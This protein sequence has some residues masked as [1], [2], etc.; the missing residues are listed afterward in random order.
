[1]QQSAPPI[2]ENQTVLEALNRCV[3]ACENCITACLH[4]EHVQ[5]MVGCILLDRDCAD[6][7]ALT[8]RFV[9]RGSAHAKHVMRECIELCQLCHTECAKHNDTHCQQC[10]AACKACIEVCKA[11]LG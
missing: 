10:A 4:E 1:M 9:A 11:Y 2:T 5:H 7:C 3:A 6:I 8:A